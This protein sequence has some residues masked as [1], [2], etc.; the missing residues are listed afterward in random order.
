MSVTT[1]SSHSVEQRLS[2]R[3]LWGIGQRLLA[4]FLL[5]LSAPV[6]VVGAIIV[7]LSS[8][9]PI[10][11]IS[12]RPGLDGKMFPCYKLRTM[13][14][15]ENELHDDH[16]SI[17]EKGMHDHPRATSWG[18]RLRRSS[19]DELPQLWNVVRGEM[20]LVGPRPLT[21]RDYICLPKWALARYQVKPGM[22]GLWQV[23]GRSELSRQQMLQLDLVYLD[24]HNPRA[25][26]RILLS[27]LPAVWSMRGAY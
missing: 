24:M 25:D 27:T 18:R 23:S 2:Y 11:Y 19:V 3:R 12:W 13:R 5:V 8:P 6:L 9:G 10:L 15:A 20:S 26:L 16:P 1:H 17:D 4:G 14:L 22:T 21:Y 7:K